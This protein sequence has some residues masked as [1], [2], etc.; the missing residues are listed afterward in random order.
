MFKE[1]GDL[2]SEAIYSKG[3]SERFDNNRRGNDRGNFRSDFRTRRGG[4]RGGGRGRGD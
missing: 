2:G 3:P 4:G 1:E